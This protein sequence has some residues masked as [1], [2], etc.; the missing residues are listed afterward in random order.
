MCAGQIRKPG[1]ESGGDSNR[2]DRSLKRLA[3]GTG[4][5]ERERKIVETAELQYP[6]LHLPLQLARAGVLPGAEVAVLNGQFGQGR[7]R[8]AGEGGIDLRHLAQQHAH[9]PAVG[10]DMVKRQ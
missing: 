1:R 6:I 3:V 7:R 4:T 8:L 9:R 2:H 10:H 5:I